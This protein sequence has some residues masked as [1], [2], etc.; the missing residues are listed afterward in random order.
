MQILLCN[1]F[2]I[3]TSNF[4]PF[5]VNIKQKATRKMTPCHEYKR[6]KEPSTDTQYF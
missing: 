3:V 2:I 1:P 5:L 6:I 4:M